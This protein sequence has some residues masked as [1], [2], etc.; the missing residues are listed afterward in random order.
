[1]AR[2]VE[3]ANN[4]L[5]RWVAMKEDDERVARPGAAASRAAGTRRP[6]LAS[7]CRS[8][9]DADRWRRDIIREVVQKM[10]EVQNAGLGEARL[11]DLNDE[12]NRL[13]REK[14][15]W[16]RQIKALGGPD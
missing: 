5:N 13:L 6:F 12:I 2:N 14:G 9:P 15:H 4:L 8:L 11:R 7:E 16:E 10:A 1:M 3:K